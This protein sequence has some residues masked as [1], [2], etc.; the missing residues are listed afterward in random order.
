MVKTRMSTPSQE[1]Y[2]S[3]L[4]DELGI[5]TY[6]DAKHSLG[7]FRKTF[8]SMTHAEAQD[9]IEWLRSEKVTRRST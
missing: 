3:G 1:K 2:L 8:Q 4:V 5:C 9:I 6:L 7:L